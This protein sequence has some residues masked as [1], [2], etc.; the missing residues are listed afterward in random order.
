M[1]LFSFA[2]ISPVALITAAI[3]WGAPF[4]W[5]AVGYIT[6]LAFS[7]DRLSAREAA[8]VDTE[9]EF[10]ASDCLLVVLGLS[11]PALL[12]AVLWAVA[13]PSGLDNVERALVALAAALLF[14]QISHPVAHELIHRPARPMR[15][16]GRLI[17]STIL[18]GH[19]A[20]AHLRVHH[21]HVGSRADPNS[22]RRGEGFYR[23]AIRA[24]PG[25]FRAALV[26]E[27]RLRGG[28]F[29]WLSHPFTLYVGVGTGLVL[30]SAAWLG[31]AGVA[32]LLFLSGY[33]QLQILM[34]DY[35]Q[36]Y[37]LRRQTLADGRLEPVG[38]QHSWNAPDWFS[39]AMTLNAPRHSDHHV[40]PSRPY[41]ALRLDP[42]RMPQLPHSLPVMAVLA[43]VPPLWR[44]VMNP[45]CD[46]WR[47]GWAETRRKGAGDIPRAVLDRSKPAGADGHDLPELPH[48]EISDRP[49]PSVRAVRAG[50]ERTSQPDNEC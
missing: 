11:H 21:V 30:L 12:A 36:H 5:F 6:L 27:N 33:A 3:I 9:N 31:L 22:A 41:P 4:G 24:W 35:V 25:S 49:A 50:A 37:G 42:A 7:L 29:V 20:S 15:L 17:Y 47:P 2:T 34:S 48:A 32:A 23:F 16:L 18:F 44:R 1:I 8:N 43:L 46:E 39:S 28:R 10:P 38:P 40:T 26:A 13:G 45:L 14:G 19:H